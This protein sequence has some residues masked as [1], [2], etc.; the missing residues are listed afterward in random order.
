MIRARQYH[1][2]SRFDF[3]DYGISVI[4]Q[5]AILLSPGKAEMT[6]QTSFEI[7]VFQKEILV[8]TREHPLVDFFNLLGYVK[9]VL[10]S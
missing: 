8:F 9:R 7:G 6:P 4:I 10:P 2:I 5:R 3:L 1:S